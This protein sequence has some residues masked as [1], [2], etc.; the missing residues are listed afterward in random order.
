MILTPKSY[1]AATARSL[2][3]LRTANCYWAIDPTDAFNGKYVVGNGDRV[4][5]M[6]KDIGIREAGRKGWDQANTN[7]GHSLSL[8]KAFINDPAFADVRNHFV[9]LQPEITDTT[10]CSGS[11]FYGT[12]H[13]FTILESLAF[14]LFHN[15]QLHLDSAFLSELPLSVREIIMGVQPRLDRGLDGPA[16]VEA[17]N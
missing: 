6:K 11:N 17:L 14:F 16:A 10:P 7:Y 3:V 1:N 12:K 15:F 8:K 4:G 9:T 5:L 2:K 13:R